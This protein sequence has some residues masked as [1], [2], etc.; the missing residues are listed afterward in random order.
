M[1]LEELCAS[2]PLFSRAYIRKALEE[3]KYE[4]EGCI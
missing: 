1:T 4:Y 3:L 2:L